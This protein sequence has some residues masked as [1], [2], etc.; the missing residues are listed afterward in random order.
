MRLF[1]MLLVSCGVAILAFA[2]A[3]AQSGGELKPGDPAPPF[4]LIGSDGKTHSLSDFKGK[5][6][7]VLA[8]FPKAFTAG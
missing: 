2:A 5:Q 4:S 6:G 7:V 3:R 8:W 1:V